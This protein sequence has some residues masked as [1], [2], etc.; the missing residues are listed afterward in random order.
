MDA[1]AI[2]KK[3]IKELEN[4][5]PRNNFNV[6]IKPTVGLKLYQNQLTIGVPHAYVKGMLEKRFYQKIKAVVDEITNQNLKLEF[7]V[8]EKVILP[9]KDKSVGPLFTDQ[10]HEEISPKNSNLQQVPTKNLNPR[11]TFETFIVGNSNNFACA[12][13]KAV[14]NSPGTTYNPLFIYGGTGVGKTHLLHAV[15]HALLQNYP[16]RKILCIS[17]EQFTNEIVISLNQGNIYKVREKFRGAD[18]LLVDDVQFIAGKDFSQEEFFNTFNKLYHANKQ[19]VICSDRPPREIPKLESRLVSRF[20]GGLTVDIQPP[21]YEMRVAIIKVKAKDLGI[22][23]DQ[24]VVNLLASQVQTNIRE[25][26]GILFSVLSASQFENQEPT[27]EFIKQKLGRIDNKPHTPKAREVLNLVASHFDLR[28]KD[29]TG[30]SRKAEIVLPRQVVMYLL[31]T[32]L[33]QP[34]ERIGELLGKRDHTTVMH[35]VEKIEKLLQENPEIQKNISFIK[36]KLTLPLS[37]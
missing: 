6:W 26:E 29:L 5:F 35:G 9:K 22:N 15:G 18:A 31:R 2:W 11:Y 24:K 1:T 21:D 10:T 30:K 27:F 19:I 33:D 20:L 12:A 17:C 34:L 23:L 32:N 7:K 4:E 3:A 25:F 14:V 37:T 28:V 16:Q 8:S 36:E 13:A